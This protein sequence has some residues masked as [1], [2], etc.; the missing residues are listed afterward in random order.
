MHSKESWRDQKHRAKGP[1]KQLVCAG[2]EKALYN[3]GLTPL[4]RWNDGL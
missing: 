1:R 2:L 3:Y 4:I